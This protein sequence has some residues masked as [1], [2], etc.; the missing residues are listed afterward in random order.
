MPHI[1]DKIDF[2]TGVYVV[3]GDAVLLRNHDKYDRWLHLGGHIELDEDPVA[4]AVR[5]AK[6]ESGLD[7]TIVGTLPPDEAVE[8]PGFS[9]ILAPRFMNRHKIAS[10]LEHEHIDFIYFG[11]SENRELNPDPNEK[12]C[13]MRW[14]TESD[15]DDPTLNL[16]SSVRFYAK[17]ALKELGKA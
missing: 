15:L 7:V 13:E 14:F 9:H 3:N 16:Y 1:H 8:G 12:I 2:T 11:T 6:E 10:D 4:C 17:T 5:E